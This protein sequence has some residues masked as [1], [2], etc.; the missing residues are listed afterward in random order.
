MSM[1]KSQGEIF[2]QTD[3]LRLTANY[4]AAVTWTRES[5]TSLFGDSIYSKFRD[6]L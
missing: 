1:S 4:P 3:R 2:Q 5:A 6:S